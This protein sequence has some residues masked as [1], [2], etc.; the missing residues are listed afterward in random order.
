MIFTT[1]LLAALASASPIRTVE[2]ARRDI[3][4][5]LAA[6][7]KDVA[8]DLNLDVPQM[9]AVIADLEKLFQEVQS[10]ASGLAGISSAVA[11]GAAPSGTAAAYAAASGAVSSAAVPTVSAVHS[12]ASAAAYGAASSAAVATAAVPTTAAAA[13]AGA[14]SATPYA[15]SAAVSALSSASVAPAAATSASAMYRR[16]ADQSKK[17]D[18]RPKEDKRPTGLE[19]IEH[20]GFGLNNLNIGIPLSST[21]AAQGAAATGT[22]G[23]PTSLEYKD[24]HV[25]S[26]NVD[27][28]DHKL[29]GFEMITARSPRGVRLPKF[30]GGGKGSGSG[31]KG[32]LDVNIGNGS[33]GNDGGDD[34]CSG[35][36]VFSLFGCA[37]STV[38]G[39][40][41][42]L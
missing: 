33:S 39:I 40:V 17:Q 12:A 30:G 19:Q 22:A 7:M 20:H 14:S 26:S 5:D 36:D 2:P 9:K 15:S 41:N 3:N 1:A 25:D 35:S 21:V 11:G 42:V 8:S 38:G 23:L 10:R 4:D 13:Y 6:I 32:G 18:K 34:S 27:K 37:L 31:G 29:S 24:S 28:F 16:D